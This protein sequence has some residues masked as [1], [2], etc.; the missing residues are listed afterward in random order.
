MFLLEDID[1]GLVKPLTPM[2]F[3]QSIFVSEVGMQLVMAD[4]GLNVNNWLDKEQAVEVL[5]DS[6]SYSITMFPYEESTGLVE[7]IRLIALLCEVD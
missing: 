2:E 7:H 6:V 1:P 4:F 5:C 3:I